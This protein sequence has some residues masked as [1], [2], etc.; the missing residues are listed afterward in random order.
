MRDRNE[1]EDCAGRGKVSFHSLLVQFSGCCGRDD[2]CNSANNQVGSDDPGN[3]ALDF[4][5]NLFA[6]PAAQAEN[7]P[8]PGKN[9]SQKTGQRTADAGPVLHRNG[10]IKIHAAD[11]L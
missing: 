7:V 6:K 5:G 9:P 10:V 2:D 8:F 3:E 1:A 4:I 11:V